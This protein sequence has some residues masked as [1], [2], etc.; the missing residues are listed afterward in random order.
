MAAQ[1]RTQ[2]LPHTEDL[3]EKTCKQ[4]NGL[5]NIGIGMCTALLLLMF[6]L[7]VVLPW[8]NWLQTQWHYG[9]VH[10]SH[11]DFHGHH[12]IGEVYRGYVTVFDVPNGH[13][14]KSQVFLLQ[15][16]QDNTPVQFETRDVNNDG[17]TDVTVGTDGSSIGITLYG[18]KDGVYSKTPPENK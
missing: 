7:N 12:F 16:A 9:D 14:E 8:W 18:T 6:L 15:S 2:K 4:G 5:L 17:I 3:L 11:F 13:P 10:V 1:Q